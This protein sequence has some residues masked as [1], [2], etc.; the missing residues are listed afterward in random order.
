VH[1]PT[2][3]DVIR[4]ETEDSPTNEDVIT[5]TAAPSMD[6]TVGASLAQDSHAQDSHAQHSHA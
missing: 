6:D 1:S 5:T 3:E 4:P 2:D